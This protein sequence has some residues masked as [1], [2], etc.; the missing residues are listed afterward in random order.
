VQQPDL[1]WRN[2]EVRKAM[3]DAMR[4]WLDKG[5]AGFRID[6]ISRLFE[7]PNLH[8]DPILPGTNAFGDPNIEHKYTDNLPE[9]H[10]VLKELRKLVDSYPG[11]PVLL[12]EADEPNI[13]ELS[14]M[15]G[16]HNDEVQL[17]MDF[18][19]ADVNELSAPKF[20]KLFDEVEN[21]PAHG[22]P[23]YFFS[24]HD[25]AR[26]WDRYGDGKHNDEIAKLMAALLLLPRATPQM[27]YG[28]EIG[29]HTTV[30]TRV[31]DVR[32][33]VGVTGWPKDKG[34]DG[35]RTPMQWTPERPNAGFTCPR[36]KPWLPIPPSSVTYNVEVES[37]KPDSILNFYKQLL[38]LRRTE[39][40]LVSGGYVTINPDDPNVFSFLR[41]Y[42]GNGRSVLVALNMSDKPQ[43]VTYDLT[44]Q[45]VQGGIG[46]ML[47]N[48]YG[49]ESKQIRLDHMTIPPFG[50]AVIGVR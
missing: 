25:Q 35:E 9:V 40:A 45:G 28:E 32:D 24:N 3:Y 14:K 19:I 11:N 33:P 29:M 21:N 42:L 22:W 23:E 2:P 8:D 10:D 16:E 39:P 7:D 34:R 47:L 48:S 38:V 49:Y 20:R 30:P 18:Q 6:A 17:P 12:S 44:A 37:K 15:Y 36:C 46:L 43:M 31:E 5:V 41:H 1:N 26:Q 50:T 27:Y 4:F 13:E